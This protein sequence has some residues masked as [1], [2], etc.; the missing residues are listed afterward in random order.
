VS[1]WDLTRKR[2]RLASGIMI[3]P[4][5][6]DREKRCAGISIALDEVRTGSGS[7]GSLPLMSRGKHKRDGRV[8]Q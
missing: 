1:R 8:C 7:A 4:G 2:D 6:H 3:G 5:V